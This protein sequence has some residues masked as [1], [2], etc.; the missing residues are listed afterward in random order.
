MLNTLVGTKYVKWAL[1]VILQYIIVV[2]LVE[3]NALKVRY[4][5]VKNVV[6]VRNRFR[7]PILKNTSCEKKVP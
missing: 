6:S 3:M 2:V 5:M 4:F 1:C 7:E